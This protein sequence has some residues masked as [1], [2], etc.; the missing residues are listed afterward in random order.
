MYPSVQGFLGFL[1]MRNAMQIVLYF[2]NSLLRLLVKSVLDYVS[3]CACGDDF[4][5]SGIDVSILSR[6]QASLAN[7]KNMLAGQ[8]KKLMRDV[9]KVVTIKTIWT[10]EP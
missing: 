1:Q 10:L 7:E 3:W 2:S 9:A 6:W 5:W 8:V 4:L